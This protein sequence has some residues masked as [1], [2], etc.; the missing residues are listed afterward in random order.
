M[1]GV[2][3]PRWDRAQRDAKFAS[4]RARQAREAFALSPEQRLSVAAALVEAARA[5][6]EGPR[7]EHPEDD[8][9]LALFRALKARRGG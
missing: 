4:L 5:L 3:F 2:M 7:A 9:A 8:E 1:S 6:A